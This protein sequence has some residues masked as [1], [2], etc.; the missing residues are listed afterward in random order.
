M[1]QKIYWLFLGWFFLPLFTFA[2]SQIVPSCGD[3]N[4]CG[5]CDLLQLGENIIV[6]IIRFAV[7]IAV[8]MIVYAG[9]LFLTAGGSAPQISRARS[10]LVKTII[11]L[12]ITL[13]AWLI[14]DLVVTAFL[15]PDILDDL[16]GS[17][18]NLPGCSG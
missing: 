2:Q 9:F 6:F 1:L 17:W 7:I 11:G 5:Y 14:V 13:A 12:V 3:D 15:S 18:G 10:V 16:G 4:R 8:L